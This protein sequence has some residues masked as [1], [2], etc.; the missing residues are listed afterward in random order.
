MGPR[1]D[2]G[3]E[4]SQAQQVERARLPARAARRAFARGLWLSRCS[5]GAWC[6]FGLLW[7]G[8]SWGLA[9]L[10]GLWGVG[11]QW[12]WFH[13][14]VAWGGA[15]AQVLLACAA[16]WMGA[17]KEKSASPSRPSW[18]GGRGAWDGE[19]EPEV[20]NEAAGV[21]IFL[22]AWLAAR[23][24]APWMFSWAPSWILGGAAF[25]HGALDFAAVALTGATWVGLGASGLWDLWQASSRADSLS[26][27]KAER[28]EIERA[29]GGRGLS[30]APRRRL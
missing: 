28:E 3:G 16:P 14:A 25:A 11:A 24:A 1:S 27:V 6:G 20:K 2:H 9:G 7:A 12:G 4:M 8:A 10:G 18:I 19:P 13:A 21:A 17:P 26:W 29:A 30:G 23:F 22:W 5:V 15:G